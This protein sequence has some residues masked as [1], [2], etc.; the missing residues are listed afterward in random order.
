MGRGSGVC[1]ECRRETRVTSKYSNRD[2][3]EDVSELIKDE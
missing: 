2:S 1:L 3:T